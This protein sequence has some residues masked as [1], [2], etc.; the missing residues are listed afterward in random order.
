MLINQRFHKEN[1][2]TITVGTGLAWTE[3][4]KVYAFNEQEAID[5]VADHIEAKE[6]KGLY[7]DHYE[8]ADLC[9]GN[10]T[11]D[12]YAE[13]NGLTCCGNHG[14]YLQIID[15]EEETI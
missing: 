13:A 1:L 6:L 10:K 15:I 8:L 7:S 9:E 3:E 12:E 14:I 4:F 5:L 11:V 2:Y